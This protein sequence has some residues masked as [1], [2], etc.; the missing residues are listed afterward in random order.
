MNKVYTNPIYVVRGYQRTTNRRIYCKHYPNE[1][2]G[3][4]TD[5]KAAEDLCSVYKDRTISTYDIGAS[6]E[7]V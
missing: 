2:L 1:I 6:A 3:V 7:W 4:F 5:R